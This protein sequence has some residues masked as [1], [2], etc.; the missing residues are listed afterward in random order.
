MT[1]SPVAKV[2]PVTTT[3]SGPSSPSRTI[4]GTLSCYEE[5][6]ILICGGYDKHIPYAPLGGPICQRVRELILMGDTAEKIEEAVL[7]CQEYRHSH[8]NIHHVRDMQEAVSLAGSLASPGDVVS[9]SP[10]SASFDMYQSFEDRGRH[11]KELV[12]GLK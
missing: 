8:P 10:A 5:N 3:F 9:L 4:S 12:A 1:Y 2:T 11:Y 7:G 6:L